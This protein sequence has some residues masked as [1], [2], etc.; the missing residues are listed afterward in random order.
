MLSF[1]IALILTIAS[2]N[3]ATDIYM[4]EKSKYA[5]T[6]DWGEYKDISANFYVILDGEPYLVQIS[7]GKVLEVKA[8]VPVSYDYQI[9][10]SQK[11]ADRWW[12]ITLYYFEHHKFTW[13]QKC[14]DIPYLYLTTPIKKSTG[15]YNL[16]WSV[17]NVGKTVI[18]LF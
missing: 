3:V 7:N 1:F 14:I 5:N 18:N 12:S 9:V 11:N 10:V 16:A 8:G 17:S 15:S 13:K 6:Q 2:G 4:Q